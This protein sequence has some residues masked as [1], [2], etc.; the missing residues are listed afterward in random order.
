M[1]LTTDEMADV[2]AKVK[3]L[4]TAGVDVKMIHVHDHD[5]FLDRKNGVHHSIVGIT[6]KTR[7]ASSIQGVLR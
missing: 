5:I 7:P 1:N 4:D 6:S 3:T 2:V